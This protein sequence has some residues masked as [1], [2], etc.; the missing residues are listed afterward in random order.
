MDS[1]PF[2]PP[3]RAVS[4]NPCPVT[5]GEEGGQHHEEASR[6][7]SRRIVRRGDRGDRRRRRVRPVRAGTPVP[8]PR[9]VRPAPAASRGRSAAAPAR[10]VRSAV[11]FR[12]PRDLRSEQRYGR[13][14][15]WRPP[16][17]R[18]RGGLRVGDRLPRIAGVRRRRHDRGLSLGARIGRGD[19]GPDDDRRDDSSSRTPSSSRISGP[20]WESTP[21]IS[22]MRSGE[23]TTA[24]PTSA[25][26]SPSEPTSGS[27]RGW[28]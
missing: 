9:R 25:D 16:G 10:A 12:A 21:P 6:I 27:T 15:R 3:C 26:T 22:R 1:A 13:S 5:P 20:A 2:F 4:S 18:L 8:R 19:R 24:A 7:D 11:L 28:R 23:S 14:A 17:V